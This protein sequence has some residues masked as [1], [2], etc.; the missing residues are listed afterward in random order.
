MTT[1][2]VIDSWRK[3]ETMRR[4]II[5]GNS[6]DKHHQMKTGNEDYKEC[7]FSIGKS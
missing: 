2:F 6:F 4:L 1:R 3:G 7:L 5:I